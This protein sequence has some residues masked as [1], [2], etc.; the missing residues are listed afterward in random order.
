MP[1]YRIPHNKYSVPKEFIGKQVEIIVQNNKLYI[2]Y[3]GN[4]IDSHPITNQ[5]FNIKPENQLYYAKQQDETSNLE[6]ETEPSLISREL[7]GIR[8]DNLS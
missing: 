1:E 6:A 2:Y 7:G 5:P 4:I 8:Y 3:N